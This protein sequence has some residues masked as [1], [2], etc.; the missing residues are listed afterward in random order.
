MPIN[1]AR[2]P[3][4]LCGI[5][6]PHAADRYIYSDFKITVLTF[7]GS[8]QGK[9]LHDQSLSIEIILFF[10]AYFTS[11]VVLRSPNFSRICVL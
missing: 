1:Q 8:Y 7:S 2:S 11:S 9:P 3:G 5:T 10:I 4:Q 6:M